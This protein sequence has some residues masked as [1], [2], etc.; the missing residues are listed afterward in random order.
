MPQALFLVDAFTDS[1]FKGNPA[2]VCYLTDNVSDEWMQNV[3]AEMN[4]AETAFVRG[5]VDGF[6]LRWFTPTMEVE[7]C[8]HATLATAFVLWMR[9]IA[10]TGRSIQFR[11]KS[12]EL[13]ATQVGDQIRLDFPSEAPW[14]AQN[15]ELEAMFPGAM[16]IGENRMDWF[17]ALA[18]E[19]D[20]LSFEPDYPAIAALGKRGL[21]LTASASRAG[22]DFLSRFFAPQSG[23]SE[24]N[25][26]GSAHCA[27]AP[28][29]CGQLDKSRL[30]GFQAS[31]RGGFVG[32]E[33]KGDRVGLFGTAVCVMKGTLMA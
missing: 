21:I 8:G 19:R 22:C 7:L 33:V 25:V 1:A 20:V 3:A 14:A 26:T 2:A 13:S 15:P 17:V 16:F 6:D 5:T 31:R 10:T 12:G 24:D 29:W 30:M 28:Y 4:Q 23:V 32:V 27:L 18:P 9:G 11:T